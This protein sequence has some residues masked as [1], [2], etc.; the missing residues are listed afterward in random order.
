MYKSYRLFLFTIDLKVYESFMK[1]H[2]LYLKFHETLNKVF[3]Y[4][5]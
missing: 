3:K 5:F 4:R 1:F 2:K